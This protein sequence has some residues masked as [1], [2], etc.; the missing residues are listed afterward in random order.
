MPLSR[1]QRWR[2]LELSSL[3]RGRSSLCPCFR[4]TARKCLSCEILQ[5]SEPQPPFLPLCDCDKCQKL[6]CS[7]LPCFHYPYYFECYC[8][9]LTFSSLLTLFSPATSAALALI[10]FFSSSDCT[11]PLSVTWPFCVMTL[12]LCASVESDLSFTMDC[13]ICCVI[14]RSE[15]FSFC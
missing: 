2:L 5:P 1:R 11:G 3:S 8:C 10:A 15:R 4:E 7:F 9:G 13:R 12:T 6:L 14:S